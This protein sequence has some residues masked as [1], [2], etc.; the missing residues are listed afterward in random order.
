MCPPWRVANPAI[1][2]SHEPSSPAKKARS[3]ISNS[4]VGKCWTASSKA[5]HRGSSSRCSM[6]IAP[7]ATAG[8]IFSGA[9]GMA[10][11]SA[12]PNRFKPAIARKVQPA[13]PACSF[14]SRV[15]TLPRNSTTCRSGRRNKTCALRRK[16]EVPTIAPEAISSKSFT[17]GQISAS[18]TSSRGK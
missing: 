2:V 8:N 6:P 14:L 15:C 3:A 4:A 12:M 7:C 18:R 17:V 5:L 1:G 11:M 13:T 10:G 9:T 16:L